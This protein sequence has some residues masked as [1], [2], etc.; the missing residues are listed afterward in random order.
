MKDR[1]QNPTTVILVILVLLV[2]SASIGCLEEGDREEGVVGIP[3]GETPEGEDHGDHVLVYI[4]IMNTYEEQK[5]IVMKFEIMT[6]EGGHYSNMKF[7]NLPEDSLDLY[8]QEVD[9][10]EDE[11]PS[12]IDTEI[13]VEDDEIDIVKVEGD[14]SER[15]VLINATIANTK[16]ES[17]RT[18]FEFEVMTEE[19]V[20]NEQKVIDLD[21]RSLELYSKE[22]EIPEEEKPIEFNVRR[23]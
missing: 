21:E 19:N 7:I 1:I 4:R 5:S 15:G 20:Y 6:E 3:E 2:T 22:I 11:T 12:L 18:R 10:P 23:M 14:E 13:L 8:T 9:I 17:E 16:S